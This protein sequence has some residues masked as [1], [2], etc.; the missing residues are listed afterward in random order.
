MVHDKTARAR[1]CVCAAESQGTQGLPVRGRPGVWHRTSAS[2]SLCRSKVS[3]P[4]GCPC[5]G[6]CR[7]GGSPAGAFARRRWRPPR[8]DLCCSPGCV[9]GPAQCC[10]FCVL[11]VNCKMNAREEMY[12]PP[13]P[14][15]HPPPPSRGGTVTW[16]IINKKSIGNHRR[17]R[18][19]RTMLVGYTRIQGIAVWCPPPPPPG[20]WGVGS[21]TPDQKCVLWEANLLHVDSLTA[22]VEQSLWG[23][24]RGL[25]PSSPT[26]CPMNALSNTILSNRIFLGLN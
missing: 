9:A 1:V 20:G 4:P 6:G 24:P 14:P 10:L 3:N 7:S 5:F 21:N 17:R 11:V 2:S 8:A 15:V 19:R 12:P 16:P 25:P 18:R 13:Q 22:A 26:P 23:I